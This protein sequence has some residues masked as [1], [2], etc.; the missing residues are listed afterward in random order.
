MAQGT[1]SYK[2]TGRKLKVGMLN[3]VRDKNEGR[4]RGEEGK[5]PLTTAFPEGC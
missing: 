4:H 5:I 3:P 1:P 2:S